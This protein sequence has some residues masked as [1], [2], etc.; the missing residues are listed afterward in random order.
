MVESIECGASVL[1]DLSFIELIPDGVL[2]VDPCGI[3]VGVN[4]EIQ[5]LSGYGAGELIGRPLSRLLPPE[6][7]HRHDRHLKGFFKSPHSRPMG[8]LP[9]LNLWHS[10]G[11][12]VPVDISLRLIRSADSEFV[13]ALV[14]DMREI[15]AL[16]ARLH[17]LALYDALTGLYTR[18]MFGE[19]LDQAIASSQRNGLPLALLLI[20]LD[21]FKTVNDGHGHHVGDELLLEVARRMR[22]VLRKSDALARLG[23]DEFAVLIR[24]LHDS[25]HA[26]AVADKLLQELDL[27]WRRDFC[28]IVPGA[29]IGLAFYPRDGADSESLLRHADMAMYRAKSAGRARCCVFDQT[30]ALA[31]QERARILNR[32]RQAVRQHDMRLVYQPQ[33]SA[34]SGRVVCLEALLRWDDA[35][36]GPIPPDKFIPIAESS[37]L[38]H[39]L[40][41]W[42]MN[43]AARQA[44]L[45]R[46]QGLSLKVAIN[47]SPHQLRQPSF[48]ETLSQL[49]ERW[50]IPGSS[51]ELE[52]TE[53]AAMTQL[54]R[55]EALLASIVDLG[56]TLAMDD[57]GTGYS[58]LG[59]LRAL[60]VGRLKLDRSFIRG[61]DDSPSDRAFVRAI[62]QLTQN[63]G[64]AL[65]AEGVETHRQLD[66]LVSEGCD[67]IQGWLYAKAV[68]AEAIPSLVAAIEKS[69]ARPSA[70]A[71]TAIA[72]ATTSTLIVDA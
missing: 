11:Y 57:F 36:F 14:R 49:I 1:P 26:L 12:L 50:D 65:V 62:I 61:L 31:V 4:A 23:G 39:E 60:P 38:I 30:M 3:I 59:A 70:T 40:G 33:V 15:V 28:E 72:S 67:E 20:D 13:L 66:F 35:E 18:P 27:P 2:V 54:D 24:E 64:K 41:D 16:N 51:L 58:S 22:H 46:L 68:D 69:G 19:L 32:M 6:Q 7:R 9:S 10:D 17:E 8:R 42:V 44:A 5:Q 55:V 21:D 47:V 48:P 37:G 52:I 43:E 53:T 45:W 25:E 63:L 29:S 56:V 71:T 34:R